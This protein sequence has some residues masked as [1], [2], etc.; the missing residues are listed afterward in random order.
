MILCAWNDPVRM[1]MLKNEAFLALHDVSCQRGRVF[2]T[3]LGR[4]S[5]IQ[6]DEAK[7]FLMFNC[8]TTA[9]EAAYLRGMTHASI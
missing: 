8:K 5:V 3:T 6:S 7:R 1:R 2:A 4:V 9:C